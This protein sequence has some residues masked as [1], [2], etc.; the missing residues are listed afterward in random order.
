MA[1]MRL[2]FVSLIFFSPLLFFLSF[3]L[4]LLPPWFFFLAFVRTILYNYGYDHDHDHD[5]GYDVVLSFLRKR[6]RR[7]C[8]VD[9]IIPFLYT[10]VIRFG[11]ECFC[12]LDYAFL[13]LSVLPPAPAFLFSK[14]MLPG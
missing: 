14:V 10:A 3:F 9:F 5:H 1:C 8:G 7:L 6:K 4:S 11:E 2:L 13:P 12:W